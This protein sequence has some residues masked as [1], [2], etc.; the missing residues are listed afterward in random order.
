MSKNVLIIYASAG[1]GH[2]TAGRAVASAME[3]H[4]DVTIRLV[5][6]L[7]HT[8]SL[9]QKILREGYHYVSSQKPKIW[10]W[11]YS[12]Y[13]NSE[14]QNTL[15]VLARLAVKE[16]FRREVEAFKPDFTITTHPMPY[17]VFPSD[18]P[19]MRG[20][21]QATVITDMG[22]HNYWLHEGVD[23]YFV[24]VQ[25]VADSLINQGVSPERIVVSGIPIEKKFSKPVNRDE[26]LKNLGLSVER[27]IVLIVGGQLGFL[28]LKKIVQD[29]VGRHEDAQLL[30][31]AGRDKELQTAIEQ[32]TLGGMEQV[33][34]FGFVDNMEELMSIADVMFS[35]AGGLT[36]SEALAKGVPLVI[37]KVIPGQEEDNVNFLVKHN[38][39]VRVNDATAVG[40]AVIEL[41]DD[42]DRLSQMQAASKRLGKP[43]AAQTIADFVYAKL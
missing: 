18:S 34:T 35:K 26:L 2:T 25:D 38:A 37:N 43:D 30:I 41:L 1:M 8:P 5:D 42:P 17:K 15:N 27:P 12:H 28:E 23:H 29:I 7:D 10:D 3:T 36:V 24:A 33:K 16:T 22:L 4:G 31:V 14:N 19:F 6:I 9:W 20:K 39:A 40:Q 11:F 32:S 13:N 21:G